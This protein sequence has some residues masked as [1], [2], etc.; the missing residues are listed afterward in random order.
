VVAPRTKLRS[1]GNQLTVKA[2]EM[3]YEHHVIPTRGLPFSELKRRSQINKRAS[4]A[5]Q[6]P[7]FSRLIREGLP[8][9]K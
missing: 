9:G 5:D 7:D 1:S 2:D 4:D 3:L 8:L 6:D